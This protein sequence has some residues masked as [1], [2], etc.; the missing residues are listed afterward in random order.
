[1][2]PSLSLHRS[3]ISPIAEQTFFESI[4]LNLKSFLQLPILSLLNSWPLI[5]ALER[6]H[7]GLPPTD[8]PL[9]ASVCHFLFSLP[10]FQYKPPHITLF[11]ILII[12]PFMGCECRQQNFRIK[13]LTAATA[14]SC[15]L[16]TFEMDC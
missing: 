9:E 15:V 11:F 14:E 3:C 8:K 7:A 4:F 1:M 10:S 2:G 6:E 12:F 13:T 5:F 16:L